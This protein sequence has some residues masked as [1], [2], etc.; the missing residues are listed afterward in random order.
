MSK[1]IQFI[2]QQNC[3]YYFD[4]HSTTRVLLYTTYITRIINCHN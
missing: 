1:L 4:L 2:I 3:E